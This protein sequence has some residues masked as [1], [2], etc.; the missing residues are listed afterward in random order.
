MLIS[1]L[2]FI[3]VIYDWMI[4][5]ILNGSSSSASGNIFMEQYILAA[6]YYVVVQD[7]IGCVKVDTFL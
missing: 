6:V 3:L 1:N 5:S 4:I 2:N 7:T